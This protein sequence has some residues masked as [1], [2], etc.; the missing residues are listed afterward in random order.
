M[1]ASSSGSCG[2]KT[3]TR[4]SVSKTTRLQFQRNLEV[5]PSQEVEGA[6][7]WAS[8]PPPQKMKHREIRIYHVY[9][10]IGIY[11][12]YIHILFLH[13]FTMTHFWNMI[14]LSRKEAT[15]SSDYCANERPSCLSS[16]NP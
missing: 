12:L 13:V 4:G 2:P 9:I 7:V 15:R 1:L 14:F 11:I 6:V 5:S 8:L 16:P 10:Y 3:K